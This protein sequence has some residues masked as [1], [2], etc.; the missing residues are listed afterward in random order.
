[1][2]QHYEVSACCHNTCSMWRVD[3]HA[4]M[5][6]DIFSDV[7]DLDYALWLLEHSGELESSKQV[8][9]KHGIVCEGFVR[10]SATKGFEHV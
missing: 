8:A 4:A 2:V 10:I 1:M 6:A 5:S 9:A 7:M 3:H